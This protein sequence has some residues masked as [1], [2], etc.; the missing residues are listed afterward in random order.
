MSRPE[1]MP[2]LTAA[3]AAWPIQTDSAI[4]LAIPRRLLLAPGT[5]VI[6]ANTIEVEPRQPGKPRHAGSSAHGWSAYR[7]GQRMNPAPHPFR[8]F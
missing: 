5:P 1:S 7:P 2:R 3:Q 6:N 4:V 8:E